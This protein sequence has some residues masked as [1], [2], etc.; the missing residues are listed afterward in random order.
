MVATNWPAL[1]SVSA[2]GEKKNQ[3]TVTISK[4]Q[5]LNDYQYFLQ[6]KQLIFYFGFSMLIVHCQ[7]NVICILGIVF[8]IV[9]PP[10]NTIS[11]AEYLYDNSCTQVSKSTV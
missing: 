7:I 1:M 11:V 6:K 8:I 2:R 9:V 5:V 4:F 3:K 10:Y